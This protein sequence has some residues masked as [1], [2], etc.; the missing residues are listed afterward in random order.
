MKRKTLFISLLFISLNGFTTS[1]ITALSSKNQKLKNHITKITTGSKEIHQRMLP[2]PY[3][4]LLT[5]PLMTLGLE[6]YYQRSPII[7]TIFAQKNH[8]DNTYTRLIIMLINRNKANNTNQTS[9]KSSNQIPIE[10]ALITMNFNEL[11][12][13]F[14]NDILHS[15]TPFGKLLIK[16]HIKTYSNNRK[17]FSISCSRTLA[18]LIQ[19]DLNRKI[20]GRTNTINRADNKKWIAHVVEILPLAKWRDISLPSG[21]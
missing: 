20:Y 15:T 18:S 13:L 4:Y 14:T 5:Q 8:R 12:S 21:Y 6:K 1:S 2:A 16:H 10:L 9:L 11:P 19:C 7:Q 17:Y 3:N